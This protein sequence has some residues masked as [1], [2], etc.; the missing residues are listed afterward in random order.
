MTGG[1]IAQPVGLAVEKFG[2]PLQPEIL[3]RGGL[4]LAQV[5]GD[6]P[7]GFADQE[8]VAEAGEIVIADRP[9]Y[10]ATYACCTRSARRRARPR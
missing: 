3:E 8:G 2:L 10:G 7:L 4:A 9:A 5:G 1:G 6:H